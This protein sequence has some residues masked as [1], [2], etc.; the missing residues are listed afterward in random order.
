M[1][2]QT[3]SWQL[4]VILLALLGG[5]SFLGYEHDLSEQTISAIFGA[6]SSGVLVGH[7]TTKGQ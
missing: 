6:V 5:V 2:T 1:G 3:L 7:F 4:V